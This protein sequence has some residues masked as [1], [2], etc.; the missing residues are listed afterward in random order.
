MIYLISGSAW[1]GKSLLAKKLGEKL[2]IPYLTIDD[3]RPVIMA[4]FKGEFKNINFP[5]EK[6]FSVKKIDDYY[7][8]YSSQ[9]IFQADL[10]EI[11][12]M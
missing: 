4:Y 8:K 1:A 5:F 7:Q 9:E 6:M 2:H 10:K 11:K 3:L 12:T